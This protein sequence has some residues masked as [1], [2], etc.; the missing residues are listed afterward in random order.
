MHLKTTSSGATNPVHI[1][2]DNV[3]DGTIA[4][5]DGGGIRAGNGLLIEGGSGTTMTTGSLLK[6]G[7][8]HTDAIKWCDANRC[9]QCDIW[10]SCKNVFKFVE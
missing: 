7:N 10:N 8:K 4:R 5:I 6:L 1:E 3:N 2:A 9:K